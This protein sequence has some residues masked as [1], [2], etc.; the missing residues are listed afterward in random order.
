MCNEYVYQDLLLRREKSSTGGCTYPSKGRS[1]STT[2]VTVFLV[3]QGLLWDLLCLRV[4][5]SSFVGNQ[6]SP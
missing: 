5:I 1:S 2:A 4:Q 6:V 3:A